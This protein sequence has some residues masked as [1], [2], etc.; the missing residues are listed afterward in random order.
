MTNGFGLNGDHG[1]K[2]LDAENRELEFERIE[3]EEYESLWSELR[4][5]GKA[6]ELLEGFDVA[7]VLSE[8]VRL[9]AHAEATI[10][11]CKKSGFEANEV[12]VSVLRS[13]KAVYHAVLK[14]VDSMVQK[15]ANRVATRI[16]EAK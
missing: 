16:M 5:A 4:Q 15:E 9:I 11:D 7:S 2:Q 12:A 1:I 6:E 10:A 13:K 8:V 3:Q 14:C